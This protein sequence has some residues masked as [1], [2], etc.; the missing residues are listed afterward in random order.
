M[1][2][3]L[4]NKK[5]ILNM[6]KLLVI[7]FLLFP[8]LA[9]AA[10][11]TDYTI[12]SLKIGKVDKDATTAREKAM[13]QGQREAFNTILERIGVDSS[14]GIIVSDDEI[15]QM[16]RSMQIK[17]ERITNNSYH[18]TLTL[19]FSP[20]YVAYILNKYRITKYSPKLNS[21]LI[22]PV[23]NEN[24]ET[25]LWEKSNR[26]TN[27]FKKNLAG[28]RNILLVDDDYST[29]N[30]IDKDYFRNPDYSKFKNVANLYNVNNVVTIVGTYNKAGHLIKI[31]IRVMDPDNTRNATMD[32]EIEN[33]N[34]VN[35]DFS[36][37]AVKIIDYIDGLSKKAENNEIKPLN[38]EAGS[39]YIFAPI[40]S[41]GDYN[42]I[43]TILK[44]NR[45]ITGLRL[46]MLSKNM[47]VYSVKY[48]NDDLEFL[49]RSLKGSGFSV[50]EKKD[51]LYIIYK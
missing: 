27:A 25:Y 19:E 40:S 2:Y 46:K 15:S 42:N 31:K 10:D 11:N 23:L 49:I 37:A 17:N 45:N 44:K 50:S 21:Y 3:I 41:I 22:I 28:N 5:Y 18:A 51:G 6:K 32:Y 26:W 48:Y 43:D 33:L 24:G 1:F 13:I 29:R 20:E 4:I 14:N 38:L 34:N 7:I 9:N 36:A 47:A 35:T 30:A 39:I 16:L 12:N 8:L